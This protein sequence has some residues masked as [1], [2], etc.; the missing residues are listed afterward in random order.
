[1]HLS[2]IVTSVAG[3]NFL[4][5]SITLTGLQEKPYKDSEASFTGKVC[6]LGGILRSVPP[7]PQSGGGI[8][9][10]LRPAA[11]FFIALNAQ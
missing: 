2:H 1:M 11:P 7:P 3:D 8:V 4:Y 6:F 9:A 5:Y 10:G